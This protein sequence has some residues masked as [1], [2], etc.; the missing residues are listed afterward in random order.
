[1]AELLNVNL[2][3]CFSFFQN[4]LSLLVVVAVALNVVLVLAKYLYKL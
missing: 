1:M 2:F 4:T 3:S